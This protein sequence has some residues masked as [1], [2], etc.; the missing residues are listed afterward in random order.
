AFVS[1]WRPSKGYLIKIQN[2]TGKN[3]QI[4]E[5]LIEAGI[6]TTDPAG[7]Y[8]TLDGQY[9]SDKTYVVQTEELSVDG[10]TPEYVTYQGNIVVCYTIELK[11]V[12]LELCVVIIYATV[13]EYVFFSGNNVK[14]TDVSVS[15]T[16]QDLPAYAGVTASRT[17]YTLIW[18]R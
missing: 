8:T 1:Y 7:I 18:W 14:L 12:D 6:T 9:S 2:N 17:G 13:E 4:G 16:N 5:T 11:E 3:L 15:S 10:L